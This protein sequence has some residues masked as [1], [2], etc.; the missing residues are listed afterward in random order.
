MLSLD[1]KKAV[2]GN[3]K[4]KIDKARAVFLTNL[5][6]IPSN[7]ANE[8]RKAV[9]DAEGTV[10][11]TR[12]TLFERAAKGT[13]AEEMLSG[14]KGPNA[15]AIAFE[16]APGVA[17]ALYEA[18]KDDEIITLKKGILKG[19]PLEESELIALAKLPSRE[20]MLATA[21]AAMQAPLSSFVRTLNAIREQKEEKSAGEGKAEE[22]SEGSQEN[23]EPKETTESEK[24]SEK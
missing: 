23:T 14:L 13:A 15:I 6:G 12:N 17:K 4:E 5:I 11:I 22:V 19:Q 20:V 9:R 1:E 2:V 24:A 7:R 3:I 16:D 10:V 21:L 8:V 18:G